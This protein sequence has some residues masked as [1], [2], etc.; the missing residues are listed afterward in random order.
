MHGTTRIT[1]IPATTRRITTAR[2]NGGV[3]EPIP[4]WSRA[5]ALIDET[6]MNKL[7]AA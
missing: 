6:A 4:G 5:P 2:R 7:T 1:R 3:T